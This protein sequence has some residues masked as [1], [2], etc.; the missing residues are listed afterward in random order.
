MKM[1]MK[2]KIAPILMIVIIATTLAAMQTLSMIGSMSDADARRGHGG[3]DSDNG[4]HGHGHRHGHGHGGGS[5]GHHGGG[6][7]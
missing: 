2:T 7:H 1:N 4:G 6:Q 3:H 5:E